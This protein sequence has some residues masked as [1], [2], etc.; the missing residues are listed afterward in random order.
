M[1]LHVEKSRGLK[2]NLSVLLNF[3]ML[4][5]WKVQFNMLRKDC[6]HGRNSEKEV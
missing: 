6:C 3:G 5:E 2:E 4:K 1:L